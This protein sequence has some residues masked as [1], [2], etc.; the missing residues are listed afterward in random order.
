MSEDLSDHLVIFA[1]IMPKKRSVLVAILLE[2]CSNGRHAGD[3]IGEIVIRSH[4]EL[5]FLIV[6]R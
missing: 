5:H 2:L 6:C 1:L 3:L 4:C